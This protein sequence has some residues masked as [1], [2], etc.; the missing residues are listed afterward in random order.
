MIDTERIVAN[1]K[2]INH[3][4]SHVVYWMTSAR[5]SRW[6]YA[7]DHA[8]DLANEANVPLIVVES[9]AL[10]HRWANDR[11]H[12]FV[13]QGMIDNRKL[14]ET[15][16]LTYVPYVETKKRASIR[17]LAFLHQRSSCHDY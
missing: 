8:I 9:L 4:G 10:G 6:N 14:F 16:P 12:T 7:L 11:I 2:P 15:A 17:T 1:S 3:D 5:R 13:L